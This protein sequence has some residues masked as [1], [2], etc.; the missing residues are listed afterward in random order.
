VTFRKVTKKRKV[1]NSDAVI[2]LA[3]RNDF[4]KACWLAYAGRE[5]EWARQEADIFAAY[6]TT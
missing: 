3:D 5:A 6:L 1:C 4:T 2:A